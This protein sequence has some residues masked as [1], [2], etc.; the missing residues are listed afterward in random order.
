MTLYSHI[1]LST[2]YSGTIYYRGTF[3]LKL[4]IIE[5]NIFHRILDIQINELYKKSELLKKY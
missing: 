2:D 1:P 4:L 5:S 3:N